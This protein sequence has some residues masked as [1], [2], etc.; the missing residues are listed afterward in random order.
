M[1]CEVPCMSF[2]MFALLNRCM[3]QALGRCSQHVARVPFVARRV[4]KN[5]TEILFKTEI[6][7]HI[8]LKSRTVRAMLSI[9]KFK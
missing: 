7:L 9:Q 6:F 1:N 3:K 8:F 4:P 5:Y 2:E